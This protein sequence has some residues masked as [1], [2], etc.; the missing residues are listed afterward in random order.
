MRC[1]C[2]AH[3]VH[4]QCIYT[5]SVSCIGWVSRRSFP[6]LNASTSRPSK[7][8]VLSVTCRSCAWRLNFIG[9][10]PRCP[11]GMR[12]SFLGAAGFR[13]LLAAPTRAGSISTCA[14]AFA[15]PSIEASP[16]GFMPARWSAAPLFVPIRA[17]VFCANSGHIPYSGSKEGA[18]PGVALAGPYPSATMKITLMGRLAG[19]GGG[20][21][22]TMLG[23]DYLNECQAGER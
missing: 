3:A 19:N 9:V 5:S 20:T 2:G 16:K 14:I 7:P 17:L 12:T 22:R 18:S 11:L 23:Y 21:A 8:T 13:L 10:V 4:M 6:R 15:V 1:T